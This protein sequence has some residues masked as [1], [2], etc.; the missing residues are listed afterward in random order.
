MHIS[1][2][3]NALPLRDPSSTKLTQL[4]I[5]WSYLY[6]IG[7]QEGFKLL[8]CNLNE[9]WWSEDTV[10]FTT[11]NGNWSYFRV[12][13]QPKLFED[14]ERDHH[15]ASKETQSI[16]FLILLFIFKIIGVKI[17]IT[18]QKLSKIIQENKKDCS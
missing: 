18:G 17:L 12:L 13:Q 7:E 10:V 9:K 2:K 5:E 4:H 11:S 14:N 16:Q 15:I 6:V 3:S 8:P 1:P